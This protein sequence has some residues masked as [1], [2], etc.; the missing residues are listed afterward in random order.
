MDYFL[1]VL[2][3]IFPELRPKWVLLLREHADIVSE[4]LM[5]G[6]TSPQMLKHTERRWRDAEQQ[7]LRE[8][9]VAEKVPKETTEFMLSGH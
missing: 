7:G 9:P 4:T 8:S 5:L 6:A 1:Q 3:G 2:C